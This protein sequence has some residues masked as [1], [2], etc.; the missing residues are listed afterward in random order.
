MPSQPSDP[1]TV[2]VIRA[3]LNSAAHRMRG[4]LIKTA[5]NHI[6]SESLDFGCAIFDP[7]VQMIAQ[8]IGLPVFQGHLGFPIEATIQDRG[9]DA[10]REGDI[11]IHNDPYAGNGNHL[12]DVAM[13]AP[14]FWEGRLTGFVSVKAHWSDVGGP[15]PSS[16]QVGSREFR[17]QGLRFQSVRLFSRGELNEEVLRVIRG[18]IRTE[19]GTMKDVQAMIAVCRAGDAYFKEVL[20]K[21]G[22][23]TVLEAT[24]VYMEQSER[25]TRA[26]LA[27]IPSGTYG[28]V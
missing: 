11:F 4:T 1:I 14:V 20:A 26:D 28:A 2:E 12:N 21:Y 25:R 6:I 13:T 15:V 16:M 23:D 24:R 7:D 3:A 18:N 27:R 8:G 17:Q 22:R 10:F 9:I 5:Y 19:S